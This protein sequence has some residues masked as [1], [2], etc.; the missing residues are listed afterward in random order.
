MQH[1]LTANNDLFYCLTL[2]DIFPPTIV[3]VDTRFHLKGAVATFVRREGLKVLLKFSVV[4]R[5]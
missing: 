3:T 5:W 2:R 4:L 1:F